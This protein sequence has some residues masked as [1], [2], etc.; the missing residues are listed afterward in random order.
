MDSE[1]A[2]RNFKID[3]IHHTNLPILLDPLDARFGAARYSM[4]YEEFTMY[5]LITTNRV[6]SILVY[7]ELP[8][9]QTLRRQFPSMAN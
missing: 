8:L 3:V 6:L 9:G 5:D 7:T 1:L 2:I 4:Y